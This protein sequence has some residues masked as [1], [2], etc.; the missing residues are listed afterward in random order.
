[1][2]SLLT[3]GHYLAEIQAQFENNWGGSGHDLCESKIP[4]FAGATEEYYE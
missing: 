3:A 4:H 1:V 2:Q